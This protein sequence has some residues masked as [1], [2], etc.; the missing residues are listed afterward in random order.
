MDSEG[1]GDGPESF[2]SSDS[3]LHLLGGRV[4]PTLFFRLSKN[5]K[6]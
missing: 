4:E 3:I 2:L 5:K 6:N 1:F